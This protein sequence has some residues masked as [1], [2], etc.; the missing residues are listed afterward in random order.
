M[1][2][3][4]SH[5]HSACLSPTCPPPAVTTEGVRDLRL[6]GLGGACAPP[7][8][9]GWRGR[10]LGVEQALA[11]H[12]L[13]PPGA[14]RGPSSGN[15]ACLL[16]VGAGAGRRPPPAPHSFAFQSMPFRTAPSFMSS[17]APVELRAPDPVPPLPW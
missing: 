2:V 6:H 10:T 15:W 11:S 3:P 1:A 8:P 16:G 14:T 17:G 12:D 4:T 7:L 9:Q 13:A 5:G